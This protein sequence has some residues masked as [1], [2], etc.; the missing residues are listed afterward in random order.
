MK[1]VCPKCGK[2]FE[3]VHSAGC[4]CA[5]IKLNDAAREKMKVFKDCLCKECLE[6][7][8]SESH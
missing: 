5:T 8:A 4:W 6:R 7:V 1:K 3:C 2:K